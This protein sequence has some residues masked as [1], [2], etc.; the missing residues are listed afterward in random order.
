MSFH[1]A[2][3]C[4][5]LGVTW[6]DLVPPTSSRWARSVLLVICS[7]FAGLPGCNDPDPAARTA[8]PTLSLPFMRGFDHWSDTNE[9][10]LAMLRTGMPS[11]IQLKQIVT[12]G[13]E[14]YV[15]DVRERITRALTEVLPGDRATTE[16]VNA[17]SPLLE[18]RARGKWGAYEIYHREVEAAIASQSN[19]ESRVRELELAC[20]RQMDRTIGVRDYFAAAHRRLQALR[21]ID[22][23][24]LNKY[25]SPILLRF[26]E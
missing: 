20:N 7:L 14:A 16:F 11:R 5:R 12:Q 3:E 6:L 10:N 21:A 2:H 8:D 1:S 23:E 26:S 22:V 19:D 13:E 4:T 25:V 15:Q 9:P 17:I 18:E 24:L